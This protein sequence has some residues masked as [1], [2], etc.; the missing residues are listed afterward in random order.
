MVRV[1]H[2][3]THCQAALCYPSAMLSEVGVERGGE[4]NA[5]VLGLEPLIGVGT[6]ARQGLV[7]G[8]HGEEC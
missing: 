8:G 7:V 4:W 5:M 1:Q 2:S 6:L 3:L